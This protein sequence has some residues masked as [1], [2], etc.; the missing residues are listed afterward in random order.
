MNY[1]PY[2]TQDYR[3]CAGGYHAT[4]VLMAGGG[5]IATR[6]AG[7]AGGGKGDQRQGCNYGSQFR[8]L[9]GGGRLSRPYGRGRSRDRAGPDLD[10]GGRGE[11]HTGRAQRDGNAGGAHGVGHG[12]SHSDKAP[13]D[14]HNRQGKEKGESSESM[15]EKHK[16]PQ[17][18]GEPV[19]KKK[20]KFVLYCEI[21]EEEHFTNQCPLLHGPKPAATYCGPA[22]DGLGFFHIPYTSAAKAPRKVSAPALIEIIE[23]D[24]PADLVKSVLARAI[25]IKWDWVAANKIQHLELEKAEIA[26]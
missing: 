16:V 26:V 4:Q 8:A 22:G 9:H 7:G 14:D 20:K 17:P 1:G 24:V 25:P 3:P 18:A 5:A 19:S 21:C 13:A 10:Q 2:A 12:G 15:I 6:I 23:V 11:G